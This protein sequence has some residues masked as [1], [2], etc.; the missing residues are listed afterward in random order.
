MRCLK[1]AICVHFRNEYATGLLEWLDEYFP[2]D[3]FVFNFGCL[4]PGGI[5]SIRGVGIIYGLHAQILCEV[6]PQ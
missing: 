4:T 6:V 3:S 1:C 5:P 2:P